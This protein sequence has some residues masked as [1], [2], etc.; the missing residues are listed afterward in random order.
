M[1]GHPRKTNEIECV[2]LWMAQKNRKRARTDFV[3]VEREFSRDGTVETG[4]E[5]GGPVLRED[6]LA[7]VIFLADAGHARIHVLAAVD[8]LD[9]RFT[10]EE[11][12]VVADIV[13][14]HEIRFLK[15]SKVN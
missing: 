1:S 10:E 5:E 6:I 11:V 13:R 7:A 3:E 12:D 9:G 15:I 8:V 2:E 14:S 4:F